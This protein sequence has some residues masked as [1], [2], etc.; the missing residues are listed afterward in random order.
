MGSQ[1]TPR[2]ANTHKKS[3][4]PAPNGL[5]H[6][7]WMG[8]KKA[9]FPG[10]VKGNVPCKGEHSILI[11]ALSMIRTASAIWDKPDSLRS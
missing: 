5:R 11:A 4:N 10:S 7:L 3:K 6:D 9:R 1:I 2:K 8:M